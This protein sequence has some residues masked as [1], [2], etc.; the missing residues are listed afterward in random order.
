MASFFNFAILGELLINVQ[1]V[2]KRNTLI[3][4][5]TLTFVF[6]LLI[7]MF[8][9]S[10]T[11]YANA[12]QK[13]NLE[14]VIS[15][16]LVAP[17]SKVSVANI[18]R[19]GKMSSFEVEVNGMKDTLYTDPQSK[20]LY[21][22][23]FDAKAEEEKE[24]EIKKVLVIGKDEVI[25]GPKD[26]EV[27]IYEYSDFECP[28]CKTFAATPK[29]LVTK[30]EGKVNLVFRHFPLPFHDPLA[31]QEALASE[32]ARE[33]GKFWEY[34]DMIFEKTQSNGNGLKTA[35]LHSFAKKLGLKTDEFKTCLETEKYAA[36][37]AADKA[38]GQRAGIS[39][40]PGSLMKNNTT[41]EFK[42][43]N[44]AARLE[45]MQSDLDELLKK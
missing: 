34:H 8:I 18:K 13:K 16:K 43:V 7:G 40:T 22:K 2:M 41:G 42:F 39:G 19:L 45:S 17:G 15:E 6:G 11:G 9:S 24:A 10:K 14:E 35:D 20:A 32:C 26:A 33:Q 25:F 4:T 28:F 23:I 5:A 29:Q 27:T 38:S 1:N 3:L 31:T 36:K 21:Q 12:A 37:V 30:N 44:G